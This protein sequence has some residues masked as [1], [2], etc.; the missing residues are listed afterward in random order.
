[1]NSSISNNL[2]SISWDA[3]GVFYTPSRVDYKMHVLESQNDY[4]NLD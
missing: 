4:F 2:V 3:V 1:M